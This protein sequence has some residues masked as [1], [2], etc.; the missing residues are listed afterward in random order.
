MSI[1]SPFGLDEKW[2]WVK[3]YKKVRTYMKLPNSWRKIAAT[4]VGAVI[5]ALGKQFGL[6][7]DQIQLIVG[8]IASFI[9][10]Q[11]IADLGKSKAAI[12]AKKQP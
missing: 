2:E 10:G 1:F 12:E 9:V 11:G 7:E 5:A 8:L 3:V 4:V 6:A